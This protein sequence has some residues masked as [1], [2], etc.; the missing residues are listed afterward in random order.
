M[1]RLLVR[2]LNDPFP[3]RRFSLSTFRGDDLASPLVLRFGD[4]N[5][6][7]RLNKVDRA[8]LYGYKEM[9]VIDERGGRCELGTIAD[10]GQTVI[11]KG[12]TAFAQM[13]ADGL[14]C[15]KSALKPVDLQGTPI[16]PVPSSY[17]APIQLFEVASAEDYLSH[18]IRSIYLLETDE[19]ID[20][21]K[22]ELRGGKIFSF[23]Y[24]YRG[25]LEADAGFL[26]MSDEGHVFLAVGTPIKV[27]FIG[28]QQAAL[29]SEDEDE[30]EEA[31]LMDF[32]MI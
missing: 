28:L 22:Q 8:K 30:G 10:D 20:E 17:A 16:Q 26:L 5:L 9:D 11:G 13:S 2:L 31:D 25:G 1:Y 4:R 3:V 15:E 12:G 24:S 32:D 21:L 23:P 14:W 29:V 27:Q 18:N 7:F 6:P 19:V